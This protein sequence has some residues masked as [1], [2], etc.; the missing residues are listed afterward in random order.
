CAGSLL[1][2]KAYPANASERVDNRP[3]VE[4]DKVTACPACVANS[5]RPVW[6]VGRWTRGVAA[7]DSQHLVEVSATGPDDTCP[8]VRCKLSTAAEVVAARAS[9]ATSCAC[10]TESTARPGQGEIA[11]TRGWSLCIVDA[12]ASP[13]CANRR[14]IQ[15]TDALALE[16]S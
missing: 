8:D 15:A 2:R 14:M 1:C 3:L 11:E 5:L 16:R 9:N 7:V 13:D 12:T 6:T 10:S 4:T